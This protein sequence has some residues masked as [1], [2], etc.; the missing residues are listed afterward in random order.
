MKLNLVGMPGSIDRGERIRL[1][2]L[3]Q[4]VN[5]GKAELKRTPRIMSSFNHYYSKIT[6]FEYRNNYYLRAIDA[7]G[8]A[9]GVYRIEKDNKTYSY[10]RAKFGKI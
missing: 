3:P 9:S 10:F 5:W 8:Y 2:L 6:F 4:S 7:E 1:I